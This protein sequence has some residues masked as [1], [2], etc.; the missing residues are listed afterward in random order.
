M[1]RVR[2]FEEHIVEQYAFQNQLFARKETPPYTIKCPTHLSIGQEAAAVGACEPLSAHDVA[3]SNHRCHAHYVAK[4]GSLR[5]GMAELYGRSTGCAA[6]KGGS[7]H[8]VDPEA[9]MMGASAIVGGSIP[10]ALGAALAS[11]LRGDSRVAIAFFGDGAVEQGVFSESLALAG[12]R[13]LPMIFFC[14]DNGY[15][16]LSHRTTRQ[17]V[18]IG[19]RAES[20]GV[21]SET[22]D[23]N[24]VIAVGNAAGRA[25]ARAR[26]GQGPTLIVAETYRWFAHVGTE[27][28]TGNMR[29]TADELALWK[30]RCPVATARVA[31]LARGYS[32]AQLAGDEAA[33]EA[34]LTDAVE[35]ARSS[36]EPGPND[37]HT[38]V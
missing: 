13:R 17:H 2:R 25:A 37:L 14:E 15:A 36:P 1:Q 29:R 4:G 24:D 38:S 23:G 3:F 11:S 21:P 9:G 22:I 31:L 28:D 7:M 19:P 6:G 8:L 34:E 27:P 18:P 16:T 35:F 10:L 33:I 5:R 32:E 20:L 30:A 26:A 12:L